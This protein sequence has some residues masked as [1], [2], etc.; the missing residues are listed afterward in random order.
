M[1]KTHNGLKRHKK[2]SEM[3]FRRHRDSFALIAA[4]LSVCFIVLFS[5]WV[6]KE[7][8]DL[9]SRSA[10]NGW[11]DNDR[12]LVK[13]SA[14]FVQHGYSDCPSEAGGFWPT[15]RLDCIISEP[16]GGPTTQDQ[17]KSVSP[18]PAGLYYK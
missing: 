11:V 1:R 13:S 9:R 16:A 2:G 5:F 7:L 8:Y 18:E 6:G 10:T 4:A 15:S 3:K 12:N 14:W 17:D